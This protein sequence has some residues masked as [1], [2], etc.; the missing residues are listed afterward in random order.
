MNYTTDKFTIEKI[1]QTDKEDIFRVTFIDGREVD[2]FHFPRTM[3][4]TC[5]DVSDWVRS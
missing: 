4:L 1:L 5:E 3:E 2:Y